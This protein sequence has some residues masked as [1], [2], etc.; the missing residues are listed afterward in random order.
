M[1]RLK[2]I[3]LRAVPAPPD[4]VGCPPHFF[5]GVVAVLVDT[6]VNDAFGYEFPLVFVRISSVVFHIVVINLIIGLRLLPH[7][8]WCS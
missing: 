6:M 4:T 8:G 2:S 5:G 7:V 1:C 3:V